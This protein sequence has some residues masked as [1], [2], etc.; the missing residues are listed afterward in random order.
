MTRPNL[1]QEV[2][3][4]VAATGI[5]PALLTLELTET[6]LA[7]DPEIAATMLLGLRDLGLRIE[8]DDFGVGYSS[9]AYLSNF[10]V[11]GVKIDRSFISNLGIDPT[12][13][14]VVAA[15]IAL[16]LDLDVTAE[17]VETCNRSPNS[18]NSGANRP[19]ASTTPVPWSSTSCTIR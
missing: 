5:D 10:P 11:D 12:S 1:V 18:K 4:T 2:A 19:R 16:A 17:G 9:L 15:V 6:S 14:S 3:A 8:V 13:G 7:A